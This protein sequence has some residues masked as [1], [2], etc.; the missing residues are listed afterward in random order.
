MNVKENKSNKKKPDSKKKK[1]LYRTIFASLILISSVVLGLLA[2][3]LNSVVKTYNKNVDKEDQISFLNLK[4]AVGTIKDIASPLKYPV[5]ILFLGSDISYSR[6]GQVIE[7]PSRSDTIMLGHIDPKLKEISVL[8]IPRDTRVLLPKYNYYDKINAAFS[9]G[10]EKLAM[11]TVSNLT[12]API[13]HYVALKV[14]GLINIVDI[15]G[16]VEIDVEKNMTYTD[17]SAKLR[18]NI[19]KGK[20]TLNGQQAHHYV[21]FRHDAIGDIGRVQRQ[22]KFINAVIDKLLDPSIIV[23]IPDLVDAVQK[24]IITDMKASEMIRV[25]NFI[26]SLKKEQIK[27]V[28]LPGHFGQMRG[29]SYWIIDQQAAN[30]VISEMFPASSYANNENDLNN[31]GMTAE[32]ILAREK[33]N[34]KITVLNGTGEPGLA[35][36]AARILREK[37]WAVWSVSEA[38]SD[39]ENTKL[40]VQTGSSKVVPALKDSLGLPVEVVNASVGDIYTDYTIIV[41]KDFSEYLKK[42]EEASLNN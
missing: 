18:I 31:N 22:Q 35:A 34:Y 15:I 24:N 7:G 40:I 12:G 6:Y 21:R 10:G 23:K 25:G 33:R 38:K 19:K 9:F 39:S 16:G 32:E 2:A 4:D 41:G 37:G 5:N 1:K 27:M 20:Q 29:I 36:K 17:N 28:M 13:H 30:R 8:S 26:R 14:D 42:E 11:Q 3:T